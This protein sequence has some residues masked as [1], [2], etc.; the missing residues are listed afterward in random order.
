MPSRV[1]AE[2]RANAGSQ[3]QLQLYASSPERRAGLTEA[4]LGALPGIGESGGEVLEWRSPLTDD[5]YREYRDGEMLEAIGRSDLR[6]QQTWWPARG[7]RWDALA[8]IL[9][10]QRQ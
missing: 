6:D 5:G 2:G 9:D 1:D 10:P 4:V 8:R 3:L 7:P